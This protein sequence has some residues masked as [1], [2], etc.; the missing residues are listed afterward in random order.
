MGY[1]DIERLGRRKGTIKR[2]QEGAPREI[3]GKPGA[4]TPWKS[5][6][7]FRGKGFA[8]SIA[9]ERSHKMKTDN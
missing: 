3:G 4:V 5:M 1:S 2:D 6:K 8:V 7:S 9:A